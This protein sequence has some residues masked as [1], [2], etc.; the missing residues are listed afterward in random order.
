MAN[1][2]TEPRELNPYLALVLWETIFGIPVLFFGVW[3]LLNTK[4]LLGL[5]VL[6][7]V[8]G[9]I[10]VTWMPLLMFS[11][12]AQEASIKLG[13]STERMV[14]ELA[15]VIAGLLVI[16]LIIVGVLIFTGVVLTGVQW[17]AGLSVTT[18]LII[19]IIILLLK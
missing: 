2:L 15:S 10:S 4:G 11:K 19:I 6:F 7:V 12:R 3:S 8:V 5:S 17:L 13:H 9:I 1:R 16:A 14:K 18:L